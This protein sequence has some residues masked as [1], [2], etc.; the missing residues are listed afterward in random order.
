MSDHYKKPL[1]LNS[2]IAT[3]CLEECALDNTEDSDHEIKD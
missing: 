1:T 3:L 2:G